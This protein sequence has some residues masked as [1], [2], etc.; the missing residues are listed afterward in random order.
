MLVLVI[1]Q[2]VGGENTR[3]SL[4]DNDMHLVFEG[5]R[6]KDKLRS[7]P[8]LKAVLKKVGPWLRVCIVS[9]NRSLE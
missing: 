6:S 8:Q 1:K 2:V 7:E 5:G 9:H 4:T 3:S